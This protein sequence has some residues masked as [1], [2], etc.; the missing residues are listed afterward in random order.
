M[1]WTVRPS[2]LTLIKI[3]INGGSTGQAAD[4]DQYLSFDLN[5]PEK[6]P[7]LIKSGSTTQ[8]GLI[9]KTLTSTVTPCFTTFHES[10]YHTCGALA[11]GRWVR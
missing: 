8:F 10:Y 6:V 4:Y 2:N 1:E 3:N 7:I 9:F 11:E 5:R